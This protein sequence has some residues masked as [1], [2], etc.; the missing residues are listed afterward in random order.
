QT[1]ALNKTFIEGNSMDG[2]FSVFQT[3]SFL[4]GFITLFY[5]LHAN[6]FLLSLRQKE[7]GMYMVLGAKKH[8]ITLLMCIETIVLGMVSLIVGVVFGI[9]LAQGVGYLLM[10]ELEF[11]GVGY[12]AIY[13]PSIIVTF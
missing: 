1:L 8:K 12:H 2:I 4:L 13:V 11:T 9:I 7:F 10:K 3:G 5:I 6:S